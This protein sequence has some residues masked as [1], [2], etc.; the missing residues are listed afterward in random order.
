MPRTNRHMLRMMATGPRRA[1]VKMG[2]MDRM[3][4]ISLVIMS[5][6]P[7]ARA[8]PK[9][10]AA[11]APATPAATASFGSGVFFGAAAGTTAGAAAG[12]AD[13]ASQIKV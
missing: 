2:A 3:G 8:V 6:E 5:A 7:T 9:C 11:K 12:A 1:A 10:G 4:T 13:G